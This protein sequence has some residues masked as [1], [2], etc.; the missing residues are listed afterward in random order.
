VI[1]HLLHILR[2]LAKEGVSATAQALINGGVKKKTVKTNLN[3]FMTQALLC[4]ALLAHNETA[5]KEI[6]KN[7]G[8]H[9]LIQ[10]LVQNKTLL[11]QDNQLIDLNNKVD[12]QT[13][14]VNEQFVNG[15]F[16]LGQLFVNVRNDSTAVK[17]LLVDSNFI[18]HFHTML[19][20]S[21]KDPKSVQRIFFALGNMLRM[22]GLVAELLP[23]DEENQPK[24][25]DELNWIE[26]A[27]ICLEE[28]QKRPAVLVEIAFFCSKYLI[29]SC[30]PTS[31]GI[32]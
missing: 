31:R 28:H 17:Q 19:Q 15:C 26:L 22:Q 2:L 16:G 12:G 24:V 21:L 18:P 29:I 4:L 9:V 14:R 5:W 8:I 1:I 10:L 27:V 3:E 23:L 25:G 6:I 7:W 32:K 20:V 11:D 13:L 30:H